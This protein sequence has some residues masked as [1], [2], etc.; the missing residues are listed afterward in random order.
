MNA[1]ERIFVFDYKMKEGTAMQTNILEYLE[2]TVTRCP[3]KVAF[4]DEQKNKLL[5]Y[6]ARGLPTTSIKDIG[7]QYENR[8][9]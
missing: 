3:D 1:E 9:K 8:Q 2:H 5:W 6:N 4:A 7:G